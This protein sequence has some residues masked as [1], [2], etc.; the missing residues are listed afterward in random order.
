[1]Q[2]KLFEVCTSEGQVN[3]KAMKK[4]NDELTHLAHPAIAEDVEDV[5][6][7][8]EGLFWQVTA[9]ACP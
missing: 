9:P 7:V 2:H 3:E 8:T 1:M 4:Q 5:V 6:V